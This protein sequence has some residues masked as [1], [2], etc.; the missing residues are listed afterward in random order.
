MLATSSTC[1]TASSC[2]W[3]EERAVALQQRG[4]RGAD[5]GL[6]GRDVGAALDANRIGAALG[7]A[8]DIGR[9]LVRRLEDSDPRHVRCPRHLR[10]LAGVHA[11]LQG[12]FGDVIEQVR[13]S[14][15]HG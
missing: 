12:E 13:A 6:R 10:G 8:R 5:G 9:Q 1:A 3:L 7:A 2:V 15:D 4:A 11:D 14:R